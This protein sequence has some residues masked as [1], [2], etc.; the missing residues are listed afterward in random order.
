M[1]K[2]ISHK[3]KWKKKAEV[4]ILISDKTD[5]KT[6]A[7]IREKGHFIMIKESIQ[8]EDINLVNMYAPNRGAPKYIKQVLTDKERD[9]Q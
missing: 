5:F 9:W 1:E 4:A 2:D 8:R 6:K 3:W 7:I